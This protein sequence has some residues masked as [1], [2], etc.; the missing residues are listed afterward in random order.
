MLRLV[1][2]RIGLAIPTLIGVPVIVFILMTVVPG[3]PEAGLVPE[4]ATPEE[5]QAIRDQL[6]LDDPLPLRY[7]DWAIAALQGDLG[8]SQQRRRAV[9]DLLTQAWG[10]TFIL[11]LVSAAFG[12]ALGLL[13][14]YLA[15]TRRGELVD[16]A[17]RWSASAG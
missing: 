10:N 12:I 1:I 8:H 7:F 15:G 5:R 2:R 3:S 6:G 17:S 14:G 16:R 4:D 9:A 11:A 13:L